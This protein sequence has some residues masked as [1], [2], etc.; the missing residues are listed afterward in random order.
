MGATVPRW[1]VSTEGDDGLRPWGQPSAQDTGTQVRL[2]ALARRLAE[3]ARSLQ[4]QTSPQQVMDGV[5]HLAR[6]MMPGADDAMITMVRE[7]RHCCS[8]AAR[9]QLAS[10]L[11]VPQDETGEGPWLDAIWQQETVRVDDLGSDPR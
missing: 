3:A 7:D 2:D 6:E 5:V 1:A 4:R 11:D 8:A 10:D 9:S